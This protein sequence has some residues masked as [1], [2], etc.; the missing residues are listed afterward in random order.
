MYI[1]F[2]PILKTVLLQSSS[3]LFSKLSFYIDT[4]WSDTEPSQANQQLSYPPS[5]VDNTLNYSF[6]VANMSW[7]RAYN[8]T[9][10][11][12]KILVSRIK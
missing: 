3:F 11:R 8:I 4:F 12:H 5:G 6:H 7:A 2:F 1:P 9:Q 10:A